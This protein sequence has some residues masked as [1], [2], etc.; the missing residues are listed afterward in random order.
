[1]TI[2]RKT[3]G[4]S[5]TWQS[6][7]SQFF[8]AAQIGATS[9]AYW[10][11]QKIETFVP[12]CPRWPRCVQLWLSRVAVANSLDSNLHQCKWSITIKKCHTRLN[13]T[14][15]WVMLLWVSLCWVPKIRLLCCVFMLSVVGLARDGSNTRAPWYYPKFEA[16]QAIL[17]SSLG[18]KGS[19]FCWEMEETDLWNCTFCPSMLL[20]HGDL[21]FLFC[22]IN[23][24]TPK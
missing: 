6:Q 4:D 15:Y 19:I 8:C 9:F 22:T 12:V 7:L 10:A 20:I 16:P 17:P 24:I 13:G 23:N 18:L 21:Q 3:V 11:A 5:D 14:Q 1:V 2:V